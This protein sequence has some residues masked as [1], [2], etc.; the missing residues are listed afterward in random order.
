MI[1]EP[2]P[3]HNARMPSVEDIRVKAFPMPVY[4]AAGE[5]AK[6]CIRVCI[7]YSDQDPLFES[8][9]AHFNTVYWEH[10]SVLCY[11]CLNC[12]SVHEFAEP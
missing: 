9:K 11:P 10:D 12:S 4:T 2:T 3:L 7:T 5:V 8:R 6:T 1:T